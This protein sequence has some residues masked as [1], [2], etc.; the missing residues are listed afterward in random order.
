[1]Y[2][3]QEKEKKQGNVVLVYIQKYLERYQGLWRMIGFD[4]LELRETDK[5]ECPPGVW[6]K[7]QGTP[8]C[9]FLRLGRWRKIST[10]CSEGQEIDI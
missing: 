7:E 2:V 5:S 3:V 9:H 1:M 6:F 8:W 10:S 4:G